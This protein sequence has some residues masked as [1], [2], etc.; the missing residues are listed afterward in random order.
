MSTIADGPDT[1]LMRKAYARW[2]PIYD[3]VYDGL[4]ASARRDAVAAALA[5]GNKVLEAGV[6]T[7]LSL[8]DYPAQAN[9]IGFDISEHMLLRAQDKVAKHKLSHVRLL[10]V[11]DAC[12]LGFPDAAFDAVVAQFLITLVPHPERALDEFLRVLR[13]GGEIILANHFGVDDGPIARAEEAVAPA[14]RKLG[15]S[16]AF[17]TRRIET[18]A[19]Q[20]P[21][22][23][24]VEVRP[25]FPLGFF[26]I[27][28]VR[29]VG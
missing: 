16:S 11:M 3:I 29:K 7:G 6:G 9:V 20:H 12:R 24:L 23:S 26:K 10:T 21:A 8:G 25:A 22:A 13:P 28:R 2:A 19:E 15:W 14:V 27:I 18:W 5:C 17:K 1:S 4:T